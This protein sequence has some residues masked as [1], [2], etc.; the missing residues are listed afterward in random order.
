M[1]VRE[2]GDGFVDG[3]DET[4]DQHAARRNTYKGRPDR[5]GAT[6]AAV[7]AAV[8]T[9]A[10][11]AYMLRE[12]HR[13]AEPAGIAIQNKLD[14]HINGTIPNAPPLDAAKKALERLAEERSQASS[15][16]K[17]GL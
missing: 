17:R 1:A 8:G 13:A 3:V 14:E 7:A 15:P 2:M 16:V 12:T 5:A 10:T 9:A 6:M 4:P 11:G